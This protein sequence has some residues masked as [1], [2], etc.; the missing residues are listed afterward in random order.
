[1]Y[2]VEKKLNFVHHLRNDIRSGIERKPYP[3][4]GTYVFSHFSLRHCDISKQKYIIRQN[5]VTQQHSHSLP[6]I[7]TSV[8]RTTRL[9]PKLSQNVRLPDIP[10][11]YKERKVISRNGLRGTVPSVIAENVIHVS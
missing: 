6:Y 3:N 4:I 7:D 10:V 5:N 2:T 11:L 9:Y 8:T 1:M